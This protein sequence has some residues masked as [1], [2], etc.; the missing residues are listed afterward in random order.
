MN[1]N[2]LDNIEY[3]QSLSRSKKLIVKISYLLNRDKNLLFYKQQELSLN[4]K[5][6]CNLRITK[7]SLDE[8][9]QL[10]NFI[11]RNIFFIGPSPLVPGELV[12]HKGIHELYECVR[13]DTSKLWSVSPVENSDT[14]FTVRK[15]V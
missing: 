3:S 5:F 14:F 8:F 4:R 2:I 6:E 13:P 15:V 11:K 7:T 12:K 1:D 10:I 9:L